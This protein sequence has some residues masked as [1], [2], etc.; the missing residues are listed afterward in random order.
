MSVPI[1]SHVPAELVRDFDLFALR[2]EDDL[3]AQWKCIQKT[4]PPLFYTPL[5]G[6][7][8]VPTR[9]HLIERVLSDAATFSSG[10]SI[11]PRPPGV[12]AMPP[13]QFDPPHHAAYRALINPWFGPR[14]L[15]ATTQRARALA[16]ELIEGFRD[17]GRCEF[18]GEFAQH[19]PIEVFMQ[20]AGLPSCDR[21]WLLA[22]AEVI[23]IDD[24]IARQREYAAITDYLQRTIESRRRNPSDDMLGRIVAGKIDGRPLSDADI[25]G[26][27]IVLL[28]G[29][30]DTVASTLGFIARFLA[31]HRSAREQLRTQPE[32]LGAAVEELIR[33]HSVA[34]TPRVA[35][36]DVELDGIRLLRGDRIWIGTWFHALDETRWIDPLQV[37]WQ[38]DA[39][40]CAFG[41]GIHRCPGAPLARNEI[42][43]FLAEWLQ[44]IP[45]FWIEAG[46]T[47]LAVSGQV[48]G[49]LRLPLVW[50]NA[51]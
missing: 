48:N 31:T 29:G 8:W 9:A 3:F 18:I 39:R 28:L 21:E 13:I 12:P 47:S 34:S 4:H 20:L 25:L 46:A 30:L 32:R 43:V 24:P 45:D 33:R 50:S 14:P 40:H 16:I 27:C 36:A 19:L 5:N 38:R 49:M 1:P 35:A 22:R 11:P 2:S 26:E 41:A 6:G 42:K 7:H 37:D 51:G 23:R 15:L 44:R 17:R 10:V